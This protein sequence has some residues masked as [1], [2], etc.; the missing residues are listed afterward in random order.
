MPLARKIYSP[1]RADSRFP[2]QRPRGLSG[3]LSGAADAT[4]GFRVFEI[5]LAFFAMLMF[6]SPGI[7][8]AARLAGEEQPVTTAPAAPP[9]PQAVSS[10][11]T[12]PKAI[13]MKTAVPPPAL[14]VAASP[15]R[16][17]A[18]SAMPSAGMRPLPTLFP[19]QQS[20]GTQPRQSIEAGPTPAETIPSKPA[21]T[22]AVPSPAA[23]PQSGRYVTIDFDN[24]DISVFIKF[25]SELT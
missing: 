15:T 4:S 25:V 11:T 8:L 1:G 10:K 19:G 23:S 14:P 12:E 18:G 17:Q 3:R 20:T 2:A 5:I 22:S 24:V 16:F 13:Q 9:A 7:G 21:E 6:L